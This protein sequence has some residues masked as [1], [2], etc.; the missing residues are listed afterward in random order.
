MISDSLI[1]GGA[2]WDS[3]PDFEKNVYKCN[4]CVLPADNPEADYRPKRSN[5][6]EKPTDLVVLNMPYDGKYDDDKYM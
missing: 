2:L 3:R 5:L 6:L 1:R 4:F